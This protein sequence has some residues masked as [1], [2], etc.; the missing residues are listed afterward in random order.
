MHKSNEATYQDSV[1]VFQHVYLSTF[2][3]PHPN[4][5]LDNFRSPKK[6]G[7]ITTQSSFSHILDLDLHTLCLLQVRHNFRH[8]FVYCLVVKMEMLLPLLV[9][10][11]VHPFF[12]KQHFS[13][14]IPTTVGNKQT[15]IKYQHS[16][17]NTDAKFS[18]CN[19]TKC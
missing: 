13:M 8:Q 19:F 14:I 5:D 6:K 17:K 1:K 11:V 3:I 2:A 16:R 12:G 15:R 18:L 7:K 10:K 9:C 4:L